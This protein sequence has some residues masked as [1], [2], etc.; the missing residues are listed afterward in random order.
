[1]SSRAELK[2]KAKNLL[3]G[4]KGKAALMVLIYYIIPFL[5][6]LIP[7]VG[8]IVNVICLPVLTYGLLKALIDLKN[9]EEVGAFD[10]F[11][12]GF[13]DFGK[14][15]GVSICTALKM[16]APLLLGMV[17]CMMFGGGFMAMATALFSGYVESSS[18]TGLIIG[19]T[20]IMIATI[21]S[22]PITWKYMYS[23]N[24]LAY[25]SSRNSM[26]IVNTSGSYLIG[27]RWKAFVLDLSFIGWF[28]LVGI[29]LGLITFWLL[30]YMLVTKI[31]FYEELS[32]RNEEPL[33]EPETIKTE[34]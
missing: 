22:I 18:S 14:V 33:A 16:W 26:D 6:T 29:T 34:E 32:G 30:P 7:L 21:W 25:D 23:M 13:K 9:G 8:P 2:Q 31:L 24:E 5:F 15:W 3:D 4:K 17:G 20:M 10:F 12:K 27:N 19:C 1:M 11:T 28:F